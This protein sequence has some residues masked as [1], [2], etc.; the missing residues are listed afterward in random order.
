MAEARGARRDRMTTIERTNALLAKQP[1]DRVPVWLW[2]WSSGFAARSVGYTVAD[3]YNDAEKCFWSQ[4]WTMEMYGSD[5]IPRPLFGGVWFETWTFGGELKWPSSEY[6]Q[7]PSATRFPVQTEEDCQK[8]KLPPDVKT[9]GPV[10]LYMEFSKLQEKHGFPIIIF[11]NSPLDSALALCG[12]DLMGRW[13]I[14]K[15]DL[16]HQLLR[17]TTDYKLD[18]ARYWADTFDPQRIMVYVPAPAETNQIISPK[19]FE[20]FSLPHLKELHEGILGMGIK[21]IFCHICG[22]QDLNLPYWAQVPMGDPGI[23]SVGHETDLTTA[24]EYFGDTS[25]IAGNVEPATFQVGTPQEVYE[26]S[27]QCIEK[28]KHAPRGF[29]LMPGCGLPPFAPPYN[30]FMMKKAINDFGWYD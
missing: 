13:M 24:I 30:V 1:I 23:V 10:P 15:P 19:H 27:R 26:L 25:V 29:I 9:A 2:L 18:V 28:A 21:H 3:S 5:D 11:C 14:K 22:E 12:A 16:I 4:V 6:M 20:T 17:L 8:L 7:A